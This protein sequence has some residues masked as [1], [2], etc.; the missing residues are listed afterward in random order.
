MVV[1]QRYGLAVVM[2]FITMLC[3]G[4]W[5]NTQKLVS[6]EWRFQLFYWDYAIGVLL[7]AVISALTLGSFGSTGRSFL[8]DIA[9]ANSSSVV[10]AFSGG[11]V[12]NLANI[13][14]VAAIDITGMAVAF[15]VGIGLALVIGVI[16]NY[17]AAPVGNPVVLSLGVAGVV[18]AIILD[19]IAYKR[20]SLSKRKTPFKGIIISVSGGILMGFFY[21]FVAASISTDF[22]NPEPGKLTP[23]SAVVIFSLGLLLSNFV[24]NTI[25]MA[26]PFTGEPVPFS[27]YFSKGSP[28]LHM[29]GILGGI[30]WSVG[31][32]FSIIASGAAGFA[33][34]Y[35]LGQGAT[36]IAVLWGVFIW[37]EFKDAPAGTN[38]LLMFM[39]ASFVIGLGLIIYARIA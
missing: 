4:S 24:W 19:S 38:K 20:L 9:Q 15:P 13:L 30:I 12:F 5:A 7:L 39:F 35:G 32:S 14:I 17:I 37:K 29:I 2:C 1:V 34:S 26:K 28:R 11:V 16:T 10:S 33:I 6:K 31:M 25:V 8:S 3:W 21:R 18:L 22:I 36:M 27:D 23:Y